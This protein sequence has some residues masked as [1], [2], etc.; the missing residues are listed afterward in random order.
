VDEADEEFL[1]TEN[2]VEEDLSSVSEMRL[3]PTDPSGRILLTIWN[4][5]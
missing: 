5:F 1:E 4:A 2:H 3:V